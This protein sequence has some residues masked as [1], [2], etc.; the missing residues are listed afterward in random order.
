MK[1][2][3]K[4]LEEVHHQPVIRHLEDTVAR[5]FDIFHEIFL[6]CDPVKAKLK[7]SKKRGLMDIGNE[8]GWQCI[9]CGH[10]AKWR[11]DAEKHLKD[12]HNKTANLKIDGESAGLYIFTETPRKHAREKAAGGRI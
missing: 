3:D 1:D 8:G 9:I 4:L 10:N 12:E 11:K 2:R 6:V 7:W 5:M